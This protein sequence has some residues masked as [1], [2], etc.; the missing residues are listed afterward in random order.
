MTQAAKIRDALPAGTELTRSQ[1]L[2]ATGIPEKRLDAVLYAFTARGEVLVRPKNGEP[3]YR[4]DPDYT[5][6]GKKK[7]V[8]KAGERKGAKAQKKG[9]GKRGARGG[10]KG[11]RKNQQRPFKDLADRL[12]NRP[13][14]GSER[15]RDLA[16]E[17]YIAASI[18]LRKAVRDQVDAI[19]SNP[20]LAS[21]IAAHE[22]AEGLHTA[23]RSA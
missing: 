9:A 12:A 11:A 17:N 1:V 8:A 14:K 20:V 4:I 2:D 19:E 13:K 7:N 6:G 22:R 3:H 21:A 15:I 5:R 16:L 23:A 18:E 10:K